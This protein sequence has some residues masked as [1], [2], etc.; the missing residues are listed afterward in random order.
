MIPEGATT[1]NHLV[2]MLDAKDPMIAQLEGVN[3]N[4]KHGAV[5]PV[6]AVAGRQNFA[7]GLN[8]KLHAGKFYE[9]GV[10][11]G[12]DDPQFV[13]CPFCKDT[14]VFK[15]KMAE[16]ERYTNADKGLYAGI[17]N[18]QGASLPGGAQGAVAVP[19]KAEPEAEDSTAGKVLSASDEDA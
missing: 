3:P 7:C 2:V 17:F 9:G 13:N 19:A 15:E 8:M 14:A 10:H 5:T 18:K 6:R 12:T 4:E 1:L 16:H 11:N